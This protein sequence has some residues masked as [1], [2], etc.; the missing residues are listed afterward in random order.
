MPLDR[1]PFQ[2]PNQYFLFVNNILKYI[3]A[4]AQLA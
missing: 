4:E 1:N 3:Y 2:V